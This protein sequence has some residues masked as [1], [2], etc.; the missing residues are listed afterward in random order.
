[1][2]KIKKMF[3]LIVSFC[4]LITCL[5]ANVFSVGVSS[6]V[7]DM[8]SDFSKFAKITSA[9]F[10]NSDVTVI[11][12]QDLHNNK[13]VQDN[14]FQL[15]EK[16]NKQYGNVEV[17]VEGAS[18]AQDY[19]K[20]FSSLNEKEKS[21]LMNA[22]YDN[23]KISG[24]EFF[25]YK[26][27]K[28]LY[29]T[30][31]KNIYDENIQ[32]YAFLIKNKQ[33][34]SDLIT[35]KYAD[36]KELD[37]FLTNDQI[38]FLKY[39]NAYCDRKISYEKFYQKVLT[40]LQKRKISTLKYINT[41]LY[42]DVLAFE[43]N[44]NKKAAEIQ[45]K[46]ILLNLK[47]T[48][49]YQDYINL[50]K[51]SNNLADINVIFAYLSANVSDKDKIS[52]YPD[53]FRLINLKELSSLINP[54]DLV[55][56]ERDM[57]E[58]VL[59]SYSKTVKNKEV[60]FINLYFQIYKK[61]LFA[62]ISSNEYVYY[63][64][65]YDK[66]I[67]IYNKYLQKNLFD[68]YLYTL[69]AEQF[70]ELNIKRNLSF[71][72]SLSSGVKIDK[73]YK[74]YF[75]GKYYNINKI[76]S[77]LNEAKSIK[78]IISG[79][80]HTEGL[81]ALLDERKISYLT[82][83]P[84]V[85]ES[86]SLYEQQY[87]SAIVEQAEVEN[88][89][90]S[91]KGFLEQSPMKIAE[92]IISS[93]ETIY[94]QLK[95][96]QNPEQITQSIQKIIKDRNVDDVISFSMN[97]DGSI[98]TITVDGKVYFLNYEKGK[99]SIKNN[100]ST[101]LAK[102]IKTLIKEALKVGNI[103]YILGLGNYDG[104]EGN[105][106][107][108]QAE[109]FLMEH[110]ILLPNFVEYALSEIVRIGD[111]KSDIDKDN[112]IYSVLLNAAKEEF[113]EKFTED[114]VVIGTSQTLIGATPDG[115]GNTEEYGSLFYVVWENIDG[116][117]VAKD[118]LVS[119]QFIKYL[120]K[121][122]FSERQLKL[123]FR[124]LFLHER[125]EMLAITG[126]SEAFNKYVVDNRL[127]KTSEVF[128][129]YIKS[130][131]FISFI[132]EQR[133]S[134]N[135]I[136]EQRA[137]LVQM[138]K[139]ISKVNAD[140]SQYSSIVSVSSIK[141]NE[142]SYEDSVVDDYLLIRS[143]NEN[144]I[145]EYN[146]KLIQNVVAQIERDYIVQNKNFNPDFNME[147]SLKTKEGIDD[148][149]EFIENY[150]VVYRSTSK[151]IHCEDF[152]DSLKDALLN[153][154]KN[155]QK[156]GRKFSIASFELEG[157]N[158]R[159]LINDSISKKERV[160]FVEDVISKKS[161]TF[162]KIYNSLS[163]K[164]QGVTFFDLSKEQEG[165]NLI[166]DSVYE[167]IKK[168]PEKLIDIIKKNDGNINKYAVSW[169][170]R[171]GKDFQEKE[172]LNKVISSLEPRIVDNLVNNL[173]SML[174]NNDL[175]KNVKVC[176]LF[177]LILFVGFGKR[178]EIDLIKSSEIDNLIKKYDFKIKDNITNVLEV[179]YDD[180]K[181]SI[182]S[183]ILYAHVFHY[184]YIEALNINNINKKQN[185]HKLTNKK[186]IESFCKK[187]K[188]SF[189]DK[190][191]KLKHSYSTDG[192]KDIKSK[193]KD[194]TERLRL[195]RRIFELAVEKNINIE[196]IKNINTKDI[197]Y[198]KKIVEQLEKA[199][200]NEFNFKNM[201]LINQYYR[202][203]VKEEMIAAK[204][205]TL[206]LLKQQNIIIDDNLF[207]IVVGGS[208]A[209]GNMSVDSDIYYDIIVPDGSILT[210]IINRFAP[211]YSS[212]LQE[213]GLTNYHCLKYSSTDI[214]QE[215][216]GTF[217]DSK[218]IA[219]FLKY[220]PL[221]DNEKESKRQIYLDYMRQQFNEARR[222]AAT[223]TSKSLNLI[224]KKYFDISNEGSGW[225]GNSMYMAYDENSSFS[226]RYTFMALQAKLNEIIFNY[227]V[228]NSELDITNIPVS[229]KEQIDFIKNNILK[230]EKEKKEL[231]DIYTA[232]KYL[233]ACRYVKS[234]NT[235]TQYLNLEKN[236]I[237]AINNFI[238]QKFISSHKEKTAIK[239]TNSEKLL[240][241][242]ESF[243]YENSTD[244]SIFRN[245]YSKYSHLEKWKGVYSD[246]KNRDVF[247]RAQII[248]LLVEIDSPDIREKLKQ[249]DIDEQIL[250][251]IFD[252]LDVIK[253]IDNN[254]PDFS[255][256]QGERSLQNYWDAVT[257]AVQ[258]PQTMFAL[259]AHK[260]TKAQVSQ[261]KE[262]QE[263]LYSVYLP[264]SKRFGNANI[265]EYVRN[266][267]F[268]CIHPA[269]YLNLLKIIE[270]L[271]GIPYS[272]L[273]DYN[274]NLKESLEEF[275]ISNNLPMD[276]IEIKNRVKSLYSIYEKLTSSRKSDDE[277]L[278]KFGELEKKVANAILNSNNESCVYIIKK[279]IS[280]EDMWSVGEVREK[281]SEII[282][283][284]FNKLST[285]EKKI[286]SK[287]FKTI[288][289][290]VFSDYKFI[291]YIMSDKTSKDIN[292]ILS[293]DKIVEKI[294][295]KE[296][297]ELWFVKLFEGELR[298][299]LGLHVVVNDEQYS[300]V[301]DVVETRT[302]KNR[303]YSRL[304]DFFLKIKKPISFSKFG[305]DEKNKQA[306]LK[307]NAAIE[308]NIGMSLP[309]EICFYEREDYESETYGLYNKKK[310]SAPHFIYKMGKNI[311][312]SLFLE[313][314]FS[315]EVDYNFISDTEEDEKDETKKMVF[316]SDEFVPSN[317]L[318]E[319]YYKIKKTISNDI[320]CFVEYADGV[321]VQRLPN[322]ST[323]FE[324]ATGKY[325]ADDINVA[326]Y[327]SNGDLIT[328]DIKLNNFATYKIVKRDEFSVSLPINEDNIETIRGKLIYKRLTNKQI[329]G[330]SLFVKQI[331]HISEIT[332][333]LDLFIDNNN[334]KNMLDNNS[335]EII[336]QVFK[337]KSDS[338]LLMKK[339][340][341]S[342]FLRLLFSIF[343]SKEFENNISLSSFI[344]M[345]TMIAN[346]YN[347]ANMFELFEAVEYGI[348][349]FKD[350][351]PLYNMC[352]VIQISS[353][354]PETTIIERIEK[355]F[356]I[357]IK[358]ISAKDKQYNLVIN[359]ERYFVEKMPLA[360]EL[361]D[362]L[363]SICKIDNLHF[364]HIL[365]KDAKNIKKLKNTIFVTEDFIQPQNA[366][367]LMSLGNNVEQLVRHAMIH[368]R[369]MVNRILQ[370]TKEFA[371]LD[372][373]QMDKEQMTSLF[374]EYPVLLTKILLGLYSQESYEVEQETPYLD[375]E[376]IESLKDAL[377]Y[378]SVS[379]KE[380][381]MLKKYLPQIFDGNNLKET[382]ISSVNIV[383]SRTLDLV[384]NED[385]YSF[386][387]ITVDSDGVA[388]LYISEALLQE[389]DSLPKETKQN[390]LKQLVLHEVLEY[391]ALRE[392]SNIDYNVVHDAFSK[393]KSQDKLMK[394][395]KSTA[396]KVL[397]IKD[398]LYSEVDNLLS[399]SQDTSMNSKTTVAFLLGSRYI[400]AFEETFNLYKNN[401]VGKIFISGNARATLAIIEKLRNDPK[402]MVGIRKTS[403]SLNNLHSVEDLLSLTDE[404]FNRLKKEKIELKEE[405]TEA[406]VIKWIIIENAKKAGMSKEEIKKMEENI[407]L[408]TRAS[409]TPENIKNIF[410]SKDFKDFISDEPNIN[411]VLIQTPFSQKRAL[412]TVNKYLHDNKETGIFNDKKFNISCFRF[413]VTSEEYHYR[414][415]EALKNS[416]GQWTRLIAYTLKGDIIPIDNNKEGLNS[417]PL[418]VIKDILSLL[419]LLSDKEKNDLLKVF[420]GIDNPA[421]ESVDKLLP[422]LQEQV[423]NENRYL[424]L[425]D[426]IRYLYSD[427]KTQRDVDMALLNK[428][429]T[430]ADAV[431]Q[432]FEFNRNSLSTEG[433]VES[434]YKL[435]SAA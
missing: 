224:T 228:D 429:F 32:N 319:N 175:A 223:V 206:E 267:T 111:T 46:N 107:Y 19:S 148:F 29:P 135:N 256:L 237:K 98:V 56:E 363:K 388:T 257:N 417:I 233:S 199:K 122:N 351:Q 179:S 138:D 145:R 89:A 82:L 191:I 272:Q 97:E 340:E 159:E 320:I 399:N 210:S 38:K 59:L 25:G 380:A 94:E 116:R 96:G 58:E 87:L 307:I 347:L 226:N 341:V 214:T 290:S 115:F 168:N 171:L 21:A 39:Y 126:Q 432:E 306:R 372:V 51:D 79:G 190:R 253:D 245:G 193:I 273:K 30:E 121:E 234:K 285:E 120:E 261:N 420:T 367:S 108:Q 33:K 278:K 434:T 248:D 196:K 369:E 110:N 177:N 7:V 70:N 125:L 100:F 389:L 176:D 170:V 303:A 40:E 402:Y 6:A 413:S 141:E 55:E 182:A 289:K 282:S 395:A 270:M 103:R 387:T 15:L 300:D 371:N 364:E 266:N 215:N 374:E 4:L 63:K 263:L 198:I 71:A 268:E 414:N 377:M 78:V 386:S 35:E 2:I 37:S 325:F 114:N 251:E 183:L 298:D 426:F 326:V 160:L 75:K 280:S 299:L 105:S 277:E 80:F 276:K 291:R 172:I 74:D 127:P 64:Q 411:I 311:D 421:F 424:L 60:V 433:M 409:N 68:F 200:K 379:T 130:R 391:I 31:Q 383:V 260:L 327:D 220:V 370:T 323:V 236:S 16:L 194:E 118:I 317:D 239:I 249:L 101:T 368:H 315:K 106:F 85:K 24:A 350:I 189:A 143:G 142:I 65:N 359:K 41:K 102:N 342:R 353:D 264:L 204:N 338:V 337:E 242:I 361:T 153:K 348:I 188:V 247:V 246:S 14:I 271:C 43:K 8:N 192:V 169:F 205:I 17:Y 397:R 66:F 84:N 185:N 288:K 158:D 52:K 42:L 140:N 76:L 405:L 384:E 123:F 324:L 430:K 209:K 329:N 72:D 91:K 208:L 132:N 156:E 275:L 321:Y 9:N 44:I 331:G 332:K 128:H 155:L 354:I 117:Y 113:R 352:T 83:T 286:L 57:V 243:I 219:P 418:D 230:T 435:L 22:L 305:K 165:E 259:I 216:I 365:D 207:T 178:I 428:D 20:E 318:T 346:H 309:V 393:I 314:I 26:D 366:V 301:V 293:L 302:D 406:F 308:T 304:T 313:N 67:E 238:S 425:A 262:D 195:T 104:T 18:T 382:G 69:V 99:I 92:D 203:S 241:V 3:S 357:K 10:Y 36:I 416:L 330:I 258:N 161:E 187:F 265:Y 53:L 229:V 287:F 212:V 398:S 312:K 151:Y 349:D 231:D 381:R 217:I 345:S 144:K 149:I 134:Q 410:E 50:I 124:S 422:I 222:Q 129:E 1:M 45:L 5:P 415:V 112:N 404:T 173:M 13:E 295:D 255:S 90:I 390:Y 95:H 378:P 86:N 119:E 244:L 221:L 147:E 283:K 157:E 11:N 394:F 334:L 109:Y 131:D 227:Y 137:L 77:S 316:V 12:I 202:N 28:V 81:N 166:S 427:T 164:V 360:D 294:S 252:S 54:L 403:T 48:I 296:A 73:N 401:K 184:D 310:I 375:S 339:E 343:Q 154:F 344:K 61:L 250:K 201:E 213:I 336:D 423:G 62:S 47:N 419:P 180:W 396:E 412:A 328:S 225:L 133:M 335:S 181:E 93:L 186:L 232:W 240:S 408:E 400:S 218:E 407:I 163:G 235:W 356:N 279:M 167:S 174:Q 284:D 136:K 49:S 88:N 269:E 162:N 254:F 146:S 150:A 431:L 358:R 281:I 373:S 333:I 211:L 34:I 322:N 197:E 274:I 376:E 297:L 362:F 392:D 27:N 385:V 292:S 23:D 355:K 152:A 139:I